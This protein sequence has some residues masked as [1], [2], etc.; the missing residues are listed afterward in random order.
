MVADDKELQ[1]QTSSAVKV[2]PILADTPI[3]DMAVT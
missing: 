2:S 3:S 1:L